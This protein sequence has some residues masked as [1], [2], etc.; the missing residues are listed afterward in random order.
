ME[1]RTPGYRLS[2]GGAGICSPIGIIAPVAPAPLNSPRRIPWGDVPALARYRSPQVSRFRRAATGCRHRTRLL[3]DGAHFAAGECD[4]IRARNLTFTPIIYRLRGEIRVSVALWMRAYIAQIVGRC[5]TSRIGVA[6]ASGYR[7]VTQWFPSV[8]QSNAYCPPG[9]PVCS[10][11]SF[12]G[13]IDVRPSPASPADAGERIATRIGQ[14]A[15]ALDKG[16]NGL[17]LLLLLLM[18]FM[19]NW[20]RLPAASVTIRDGAFCVEADCGYYMMKSGSVADITH[21]SVWRR[22]IATR[23][24]QVPLPRSPVQSGAPGEGSV[25]TNC[26][27]GSR[28]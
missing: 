18:K 2:A 15:G 14:H 20:V 7:K 6:I 23:A 19:S 8:R 1:K 10:F 26:S 13:G 28:R 17:L 4:Q 24:N 11:R 27:S 16:H 9:R 12:V 22:D 5:G 3:N 25:Q 21:C